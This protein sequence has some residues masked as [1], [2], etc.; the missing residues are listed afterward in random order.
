[1]KNRKPQKS[2]AMI[3]QEMIDCFLPMVTA[4]LT[5]L[6]T[7][8]SRTSVAASLIKGIFAIYPQIL[9]T[10]MRNARLKMMRELFKGRAQ[11][12]DTVK[13][14]IGVF[15]MGNSSLYNSRIF[16]DRQRPTLNSLAKVLDGA[17]IEDPQRRMQVCHHFGHHP[18]EETKEAKK[19]RRMDIQ[20]RLDAIGLPE[21]TRLNK[22]A[23][24]ALFLGLTERRMQNLTGGNQKTSPA[25][26][27]HF[28]VAL[29]QPEDPERKE[30][31]EYCR[32]YEAEMEALYH[33][34][35]YHPLADGEADLLLRL[36][37]AYFRRILES[38]EVESDQR[39]KVF[40]GLVY[41]LT[42]Y[43]DDYFGE[44]VE[45]ERILPGMMEAL[46]VPASRRFRLLPQMFYKEEEDTIND[47]YD[48]LMGTDDD[49]A[50]L[51]GSI[52]PVREPA[53][54][55]GKETER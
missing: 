44:A 21:D 5:V 30:D 24:Q 17:G 27:F 33:L 42:D 55:S 4:D 14:F 16:E 48:L 22:K 26:A 25:N 32:K 43:C 10:P 11:K 53:R 13:D 37:I 2:P 9:M 7:V 39:P 36:C 50:M 52:L 34:F 47:Y 8:A 29:A 35:G 23:Y 12:L 3:T 28:I 46:D 41:V 38:L 40:W 54:P 15:G 49:N 18:G 31:G 19:A 20:A 1:M 51:K 45:G 6:T